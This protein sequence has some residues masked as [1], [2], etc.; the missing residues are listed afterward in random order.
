MVVYGVAVLAACYLI[1]QIMGEILGSLLHIDANVGGVGF[2]M[3][4]LIIVSQWMHTK[5]PTSTETDNGVLFWSKMYIPVIV[6]M[7]ATQNVGVALAG[8]WIALLAGVLPVMI[9]FLLVP[10]F[11]KFTKKQINP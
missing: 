2:A 7:S 10:V 5:K 9:C 1:G 4:L 3:I 11:T 6:A 8:G